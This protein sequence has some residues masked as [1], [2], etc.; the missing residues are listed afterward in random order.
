M[1]EVASLALFNETRLG[2]VLLLRAMRVRCVCALYAS[3]EQSHP[4]TSRNLAI[5]RESGLL[6][7]RKQGK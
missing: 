6:R 2:I 7:D 5:L 1:P 4:T 3:L